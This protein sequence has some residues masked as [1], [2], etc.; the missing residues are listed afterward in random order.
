MDESDF[1]QKM[2]EVDSTLAARKVAALWR[3]IFAWFE[4]TGLKRFDPMPRDAAYPAFDGP[5]LFHEIEA[6]Y[7]KHYPHHATFQ[8][9]WGSRWFIIRGEFYRA[10][11]PVV[12][13]PTESLDPFEFM[14]E[15]PAPLLELLSADEKREIWDTFNAFFRQASDINLNMTVWRSESTGL[16][17][18]LVERGWADLRD[19]GN[20]FRP[21]D[22][23]SVLFTIQQAAEKYLKAL[24]VAH[25][26]ATTEEKLRKEYGHDVCKLLSACLAL[27]PR[28][29]QLESHLDLLAYGPNVRYER[30]DLGASDVIARMNLAYAICHTSAKSLLYLRK[31][32]EASSKSAASI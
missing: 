26:T 10:R 11:I 1:L 21:S 4:I 24:L 8:G 25:G 28:L 30:A 23:T 32:H 29:A 12:F 15:L 6:W 13:N 27:C 16:L 17:A 2:R 19:A 5:N 3:P 31:G 22:P 20:A 18:E 7:G 14:R 9:D